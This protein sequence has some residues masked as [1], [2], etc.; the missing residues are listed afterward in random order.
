MIDQ[1]TPEQRLLVEAFSALI[2]RRMCDA[3]S[4]IAG[5][6]ARTLLAQLRDA[7]LARHFDTAMPD[8]TRRQRLTLCDVTVD[9]TTDSA[10]TLLHEWQRRARLATQPRKDPR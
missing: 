2:D 3:V 1:A 5:T 9:M 7:G 8:R 4:P 10:L 6:A